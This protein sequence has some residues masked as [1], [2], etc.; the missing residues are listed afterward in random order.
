MQSVM[1]Q[2]RYHEAVISTFTCKWLFKWY[3]VKPF[4]PIN[5][6]TDLGV[7]SGKDSA[8]LIA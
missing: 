5:L 3:K 4:K 7:A 1:T 8:A 2:M 6:K